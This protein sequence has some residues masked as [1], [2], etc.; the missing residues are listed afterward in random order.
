MF[1]IFIL[2]Y[3]N[4]E[5]FEDGSVGYVERIQYIVNAY[6]L[7]VGIFTGRKPP[8]ETEALEEACYNVA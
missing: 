5:E 1:V 2:G 6:N 3:I 4:K 8:L 7:F